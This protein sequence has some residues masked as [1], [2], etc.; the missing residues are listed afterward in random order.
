[1]KNKL[2]SYFF[3]VAF[4]ASCKDDKKDLDSTLFGMW[5]VTKVQGQQYLNGNAGVNLADNSPTGTVSA[6][7]RETSA[8]EAKP[9][10]AT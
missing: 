2:L 7:S 9:P 1:M 6:P 4:L 8:A 5:N 3:L 10:R